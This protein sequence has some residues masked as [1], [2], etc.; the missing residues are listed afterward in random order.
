VLERAPRL[1]DEPYNGALRRLVEV[2]H[3]RPLGD[4]SQ[5]GKGRDAI[6]R[7]LAEHLLARY[8]MPAM[9]WSVFFDGR[10]A[11]RLVPVVVHVAGGGSLFEA[12]RD[13]SFPLPLTRRMC[14]E[15]LAEAWSGTFLQAIRRVQV[16][17]AGGDARLFATWMRTARAQAIGSR[18]EEAFW[19]TVIAWL[20][21]NPLDAMQIGP[22]MDFIV[23]RRHHDTTFSMT[24]RSAAA[25]IRGMQEWH[26]ELAQ[27]KV[28]HGT[29]FEPS[30]LRPIAIDLSERGR[31]G[32]VRKQVWR[33]EEVLNAKDLAAEGRRMGHCVYSYA[34]AIERRQTSIWTMTLEDGDGETGRWAMLTVEVRNESKRIVQ[35][36]G[37]FNRGA[38]SAEHKILLRWAGA[39]GLA[40]CIGS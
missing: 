12:V 25:M 4:W 7:S 35:A 11:G 39:N 10:N 38:T 28:I 37:R 3:V 22:L 9:L 32:A 36:R 21:K 2:A 6:F 33:V 34:W 1:A 40:V 18:E 24:G 30:G 23:H 31:E 19:T 5:R 8:A 27:E 13:P 20:A 17:A 29:V 15:L 16:R 14:H 26:R